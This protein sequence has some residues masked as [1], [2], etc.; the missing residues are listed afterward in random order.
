[1]GDSAESTRLKESI[2]DDVEF[3][4]KVQRILLLSEY[5]ETGSHIN[6]LRNSLLDEKK[7]ASRY[8]TPK[9]EQSFI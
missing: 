9:L 2:Q 6:C 8:K 3:S 4:S 7:K 5:L 1:M